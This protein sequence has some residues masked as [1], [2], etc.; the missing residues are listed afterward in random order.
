[1]IVRYQLTQISQHLIAL[2]L[3]KLIQLLNLVKCTVDTL[4]AG[5]RIRADDGMVGDQIL[6]N[7]V[8]STSRARADLELN[9]LAGFDEIRISMFSS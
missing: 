5:D 7:I 4:P 2:L 3:Y 8:S 6:A 9:T 1:V